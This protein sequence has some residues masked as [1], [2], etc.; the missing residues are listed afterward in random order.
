MDEKSLKQRVETDYLIGCIKYKSA[1]QFYLMPLAWWILDYQTYDPSIL[2]EDKFDFRDGIYCVS[3]NKIEGYLSSISEDR[4]SFSEV[5]YIK[6]NWGEEYSQV[7]VFIDFDERQYIS[8]FFDVSIED[9]LPN[10]QWIG[11]FDWN[12]EESLPVDF[13]N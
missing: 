9:Y 12:L 4:I 6:K 13:S 2:Q 5:Q 11:R 1:Y 8:A 10:D 7:R 3:D